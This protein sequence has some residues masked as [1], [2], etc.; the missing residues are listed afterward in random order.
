MW[1]VFLLTVVDQIKESL[2][3]GSRMPQR[4]RVGICDEQDAHLELAWMG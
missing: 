4:A 3:L 1:D 2:Q